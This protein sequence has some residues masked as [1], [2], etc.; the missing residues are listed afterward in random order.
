M[1]T[2]DVPCED[3]AKELLDKLYGEAATHNDQWF[4]DRDCIAQALTD[5]A[6]QE[7]VNILMKNEPLVALRIAA[8]KEG[9]HSEGYAEAIEAAEKVCQVC[10]DHEFN[11]CPGVSEGLKAWR[12]SCGT[13]DG[14]GK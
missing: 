13:G 4:S 3:V 8:A 1:K 6:E 7:Q 11:P 5:Y 2:A 14:E 12:T 9:A 10:D